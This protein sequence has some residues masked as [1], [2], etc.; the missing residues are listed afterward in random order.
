MIAGSTWTAIWTEFPFVLT[1]GSPKLVTPCL[2]MQAEYWYADRIAELVA[3]V[4]FEALDAG[5]FFAPP[6]AETSRAA[7]TASAA[8]GMA[9]ERQRFGFMAP[10]YAPTGA[11]IVTRIVTPL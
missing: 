8:G 11:G 7:A 5:G 4:R 9:R 3:A 10:L 1:C 6:Q 2:R